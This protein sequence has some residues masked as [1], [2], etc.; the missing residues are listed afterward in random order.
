MLASLQSVLP[1]SV[2]SSI[3]NHPAQKNQPRQDADDPRE[4]NDIP[5]TSSN[6]RLMSVDEQGVKKKKGK[7]NEVRLSFSPFLP[8]EAPQIPMRFLHPL[9][10]PPTSLVCLPSSSHTNCCD[11]RISNIF[12][13]LYRHSSSSD[14]RPQ[15]QTTLS[16]SRSNSYHPVLAITTDRPHLAVPLTPWPPIPNTMANLP[17]PAHLPI[18]P[19]SLLTPPMLHPSHPSTLPVP[20]RLLGG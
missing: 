11:Y 15:R 19:T 8:V 9:L 4:R 20:Q 13:S 7:S 18:V 12:I 3:S 17:S 5:S 16:T 6:T 14:R 10:T 1:S 2:L